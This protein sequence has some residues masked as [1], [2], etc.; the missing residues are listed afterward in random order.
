MSAGIPSIPNPPRE[1]EKI[2]PWCA[3]VWKYLRRSRIIAGNGIRATP[4][5]GGLILSA[6]PSAGLKWGA[7]EF[8]LNNSTSTTLT[9]N[10]GTIVVGTDVISIQETTVTAA[11]GTEGSPFYAQVEVNHEDLANSRI[12]PVTATL[13]QSDGFTRIPLLKCYLESSVLKFPEGGHICHVG[14][15]LL[16]SFYSTA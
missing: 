13:F 4:T 3:D 1:K 12:L 9:F 6:S 5:D 8:G 14:S 10:A 16:P 11:G 7:F 15:I 2:L